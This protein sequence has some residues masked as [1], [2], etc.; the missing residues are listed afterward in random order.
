M[1]NLAIAASVLVVVVIVIFLFATKDKNT[2]DT[3]IPTPTPIA[4]PSVAIINQN[5]KAN[6]NTLGKKM[7]SNPPSPLPKSEIENKKTV[8]ETDKGNIIIEL[9]P[10]IPLA[11]S[12][13]IFL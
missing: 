12:N 1:K 9:S 6:S 3:F 7:Y 5:Q 13:F 11:S 8:I 4:S 2:N 10:D